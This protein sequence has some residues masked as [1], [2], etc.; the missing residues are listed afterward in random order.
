MPAYN[1]NAV[2]PVVMVPNVA[3]R[4]L[5]VFISQQPAVQASPVHQPPAITED[6]L[7][8]VQ[9]MFPNVDKEVIKS[10]L[11]ANQGNKQAAINS[12]LQMTDQ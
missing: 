3:G 5:P 2:A 11:E 10:V 7:K 6:D 1:C 4:P 12:L 8:Q 9:E